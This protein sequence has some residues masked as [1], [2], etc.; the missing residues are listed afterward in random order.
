MSYFVFYCWLFIC[1]Q[2]AVADLF[3]CVSVRRGFHFLWVLR[4]GCVILLSHSLSL[5]YNSF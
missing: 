5:Q 2:Y 1:T 4:I 3:T